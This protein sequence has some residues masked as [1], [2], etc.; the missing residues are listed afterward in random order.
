MYP[1][2]QLPNTSLSRRKFPEP[3]DGDRRETRESEPS[4]IPVRKRRRNSRRSCPRCKE[5]D[6]VMEEELDPQDLYCL[7]CGVCFRAR[8]RQG[9]NAKSRQMSRNDSNPCVYDD[10]QCQNCKSSMGLV[11]D[12][13]SGDLVC[14]SCGFVNDTGGRSFSRNLLLTKK[15]SKNYSRKVH[16]RQRLAQLRGEDPQISDEYIQ[17]IQ[18]HISEMNID[19]RRTGKKNFGAICVI[20]GIPKKTSSGWIQIRNELGLFPNTSHIT[21]LDD[22]NFA[23]RFEVRYDC[24]EAAFNATLSSKHGSTHWLKR[25]NIVNLNY[26]LPQI[27]RLESESLW[28]ECAKFFKQ[29]THENHPGHNNERWRVIVMYCDR[30]FRRARATKEGGDLLLEWPYFPMTTEEILTKYNYFY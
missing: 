9:R 1:V 25:T 2:P 3:G 20:L 21:E 12:H 27:L 28:D 14:T 4:T 13:V 19:T 18:E 15:N 7:Q 16:L 29:L 6:L 8:G 30:H 24:I 11:V 5:E 22:P 26:I 23:L 17:R 10:F